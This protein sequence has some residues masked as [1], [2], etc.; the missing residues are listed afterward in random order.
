MLLQLVAAEA[1]GY[2]DKSVVPV[3]DHAGVTILEKGM[4]YHR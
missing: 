1:N 2:F 4:K 3:K